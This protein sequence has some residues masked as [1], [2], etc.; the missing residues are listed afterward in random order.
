MHTYLICIGVCVHTD[1][2]V[3]WR[4]KGG[5]KERRETSALRGVE[6]LNG[7]RRLCYDWSNEYKL[8][9][10]LRGGNCSGE[11]MVF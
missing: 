1:I 2:H 6:K 11:G 9:I 10:S 7:F 4:N 5:K 8:P 3:R